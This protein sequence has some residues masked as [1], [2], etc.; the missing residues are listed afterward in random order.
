MKNQSKPNATAVESTPA[1]VGISI[2]KENFARDY[3]I[4]NADSTA[5]VQVSS[6]SNELPLLNGQGEHVEGNDGRMLNKHIINCKAVPE[7]SV[8]AIKELFEGR[9]SV[10]L[11]ELSPFTLSF[12][13][14]VPSSGDINLPFKGQEIV[15]QTAMFA[16]KKHEGTFVLGITN[17]SVP[18]VAKA[19]AFSFDSVLEDAEI[20]MEDEV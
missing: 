7:G 3:R 6:V 16:S 11:G 9:E 15:V 5:K 10:D 12:N 18:K 19:K 13:A 4:L 2:S 14:I 8:K 1:L 20:E 17:I